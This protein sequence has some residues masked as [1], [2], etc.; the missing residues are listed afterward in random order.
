MPKNE[1]RMTNKEL[2]DE[3]SKYPLKLDVSIEVVG[4]SGTYTIGEIWMNREHS[5]IFIH[6]TV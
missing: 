2:I 4:Q 6:G 3:L 1:P 5:H